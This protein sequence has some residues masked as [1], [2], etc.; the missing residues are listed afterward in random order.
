MKR[1]NG[2]RTALAVSAAVLLAGSAGCGGQGS[3][4]APVRID[5][6]Q[7]AGAWTG[8]GG[9]R[10]DF[11]ADGRFEMSGI[12]RDAVVFSFI[13][14]PA[15]D[16]KLSGTGTWS[17]LDAGTAVELSYDAGGSFSDDSEV[18]RLGVAGSEDHPELYFSTNS[19]KE[20]GYRIR[21]TG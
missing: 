2:R 12:P 16:G 7:V 10:V 19:D 17:T 1:W 6:S 13:E 11:R 21:K 3:G 5:T 14:P 20:Y 18:G 8:D 15:G 9:G 4:S